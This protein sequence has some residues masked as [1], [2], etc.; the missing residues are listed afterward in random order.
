ML[1][2]LIIVSYVCTYV[3]G[4]QLITPMKAQSCVALAT[5][6]PSSTVDQS[7]GEEC[8]KQNFVYANSDS[9]L[10]FIMCGHCSPAVVW[11]NYHDT[12]E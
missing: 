10:L 6:L 1:L 5:L 8:F 7:T 4:E 3:A 11:Y 12:H 2:I 9:G